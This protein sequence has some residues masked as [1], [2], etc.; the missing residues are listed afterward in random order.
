[1]LR[2]PRQLLHSDAPS[3]KAPIPSVAKPH[4]YLGQAAGIF[5]HQSNGRVYLLPSEGADAVAGCWPS[6]RGPIR[7][8]PS[9]RPSAG[10]FTRN[11]AIYGL[12]AIVQAAQGEQRVPRTESA[13][14]VPERIMQSASRIAYECLRL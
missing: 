5:R 12:E 3:D 6:L 14:H 10:Q 11:R 4:C 13:V 7:L 8:V 9:L 1:M 2:P